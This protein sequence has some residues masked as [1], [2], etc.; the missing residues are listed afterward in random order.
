MF[1]IDALT[2]AVSGVCF[3]LLFKESLNLFVD[4]QP[5]NF[6]M[7]LS[8]MTFI[9]LQFYATSWQVPSIILQMATILYSTTLIGTLYFSMIRTR[10]LSTTG[11]LPKLLAKSTIPFCLLILVAR[12]YLT[13]LYMAEPNSKLILYIHIA[14]LLPCVAIRSTLDIIAFFKIYNL[15][16]DF[17]TAEVSHSLKLLLI[18]LFFELFL[19]G[20][21]FIFSLNSLFAG[22]EI[23]LVDWLMISWGVCTSLH[24]KSFFRSVFQ[25]SGHQLSSKGGV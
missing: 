16:Q 13:F 14:T 24:Q 9:S 12:S 25:T 17:L 18:N 15:R 23:I 6:V 2:T 11:K 10:A 3:G 19:S 20:C 1:D 7:S 21:V 22:P 5:L 8:F 4:F